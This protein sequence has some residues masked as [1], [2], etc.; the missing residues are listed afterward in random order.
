MDNF[1]VILPMYNY[2]TDVESKAITPLLDRAIEKGSKT[3]LK[4]SMRFGGKEY[5]RWID[6]AYLLIGKAYFYKQ[7]YFSAR[8][9]FSFVM[10]E[11]EDNPIKYEAMLWLART[12]IQLEQFEK[13][14]PLLNLIQ[15][16]MNEEADIPMSVYREFPLVHADQF[17]KQG[18]YDLAIS[19]LYDG[20]EIAGDK[21]L[22]TRAKFILAQIYQEEGNQEMAFELYADVIRRNPVYEM[23]FQSKINMA[24]AYESGSEDSKTI[25]K[26][27][28]RMLKDDKN[29]D[30]LDQ[31]YYALSEVAFKDAND[32]LGMHY[33]KLSVAK[34]VNNNYQKS[35]SSLELA[36]IYFAMPEYE[37]SQA[38]YDTAV[39]YLPEDYPD[40]Q[41]IK[42]KADKLSD[43]VANLQVIQYEDSLQMLS[44]MSEE[45]RF[46]VI[47][48]IIQDL[49]DE[50]QRQ[51][52][53]DELA[54]TMASFDQGQNS[55]FNTG[56]P[57]GGAKWYF[58]NTNTLSNGYSEF[59]RKWGKRKLE[60]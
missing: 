3:I 12:Y 28:T 58:Y 20:I 4:H 31:I 21:Q 57:I 44:F 15:S 54:Q 60:D 32:T 51:R 41:A 29:K 53:A 5:I 8:R 56:V 40:Y 23:A 42:N 16:D 27:L 9:S 45:E 1:N 6:N 38:Y 14:E 37:L 47:D 25:I 36:D 52:E 43:L 35:T 7:D 19:Y 39:T 55:G 50:E 11:Y 24:E 49:I 30:Y 22:K 48:Q 33:L 26:Y 2:G 18:Y 13:S 46:S 34:S 17:I 59:I 10:R